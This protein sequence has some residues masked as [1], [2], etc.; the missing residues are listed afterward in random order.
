[1]LSVLGA[2]LAVGDGQL[3]LKSVISARTR[4]FS[5]SSNLDA[6]SRKVWLARSAAGPLVA[7]CRRSCSISWH[8]RINPQ[9]CG[10]IRPDSGQ[11]LSVPHGIGSVWATAL[12]EMHWALVNGVRE[13][14]LPGAGFREDLFDL[15]E[16]LAGNQVA[17][18]LVMDGLK[19]QSCLPTF[20]DA[21]DAILQADQRDFGAAHRCIIWW[22]FAKRGM[23]VDSRDGEDPLGTAWTS[24]RT[25]PCRPTAPA[26]AAG[27]RWAAPPS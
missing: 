18:R 15:S 5:S 13:L 6:L 20:L 2:P 7:W 23:G 12:W 1:V 9:T 4:R 14:R 21:R 26:V 16:P 27:R 11:N 19:L 3:T 17:L 10:D 25:S 24:R 8:M 22:A